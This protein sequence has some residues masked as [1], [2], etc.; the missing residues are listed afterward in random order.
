MRKLFYIFVAFT[1]AACASGGA[2]VDSRVQSNESLKF[3]KM[4]ISLNVESRNF[5][6]SLADGMQNSIVSSLAGCGIEAVVY[7]KDALDINPNKTL[8]DKMRDF[9]ADSMLSIVRTGGQVLISDGGNNANFDVMLRLYKLKPTSSE[10]W[11]A[12]SDVSVLTQ[13]LFV[14]ET[15]SGERL[16]IKF[17]EVMKRDGVVCRL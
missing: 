9:Q 5:T 8:A 14:N 4:L 2:K 6:K 13:N 7:V 12:K 16:G 17:F 3:K 1:L 10:V 15:K 11:T